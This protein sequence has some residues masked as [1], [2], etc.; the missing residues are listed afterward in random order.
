MSEVNSATVSTTTILTSTTE[1]S[2]DDWNGD[3]TGTI[4]VILLVIL[5]SLIIAGYIGYRKLK[6]RRRSHGEYRPQFEEYQHAKNLP[7]LQPP[8]IEGLI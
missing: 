5:I 4:V 1:A 6:E 7:Y 8:S 3:K 2:D